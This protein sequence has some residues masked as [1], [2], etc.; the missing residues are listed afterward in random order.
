MPDSTV[1]TPERVNV[2]AGSSLTPGEL[3]GVGTGSVRRSSMAFAAVRPFSSE[4]GSDCC[5]GNTIPQFD[6][7]APN[8]PLLSVLNP[9]T[10]IGATRQS[11]IRITKVV[12]A[13]DGFADS[14]VQVPRPG[15]A[16][17]ITGRRG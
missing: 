17:T 14:D 4:T 16:L 2:A 1:T 6:C 15:S 5:S 10:Q 11:P 12:I 7:F 13:R 8:P 9:I 3:L